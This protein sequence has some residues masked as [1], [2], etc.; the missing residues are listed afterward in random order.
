MSIERADFDAISEDD[1]QQLVDGQVPEGLRL[2]YKQAA[3]GTSDADKRELQKD[4]SALANASGGHLIIGIAEGD[5][6]A[7]ELIGLDAAG[8]D[9][10]LLRMENL[11]RS[12]IEP[13]IAGLRM[14]QIPLANG[15]QVIVLRIPR[16]WNSPHRVIA[17]G[18]NRFYLR[19]SAGVHE[20][21]MEELRAMFNRSESA[22][23][24]AM[25]FRDKRLALIKSGETWKPV[26]GKGQLVMH[27][28]PT[29]SFSGLIH[30]DLEQVRAAES[31]LRPINPESLGYTPR[32]NYEGF[33]ICDN[34]SAPKAYTQV[35]RDG[36]IEAVV[37]G[38]VYE[39]S[40]HTNVYATHVES[41]IFEGGINCIN[42]LRRLDVPPSLIVMI[43][44][45][46][47]DGAVYSVATGN[48]SYASYRSYA[49][50][51]SR[52]VVL[53]PP[54]VLEDYGEQ[55]TYHQ[56]LRPA[57]D[58]LWNA[59]GF[60]KAAWFNDDGMWVRPAR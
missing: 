6:V 49:Q 32:F 10:E 34:V 2:E 12:G 26:T 15:R 20:P 3:Y 39:D 44:L 31:N 51:I 16:S 4:V 42:A 55:I 19:H 52:E 40:G 36:C 50:P 58:T 8:V 29:A 37:S 23:D 24:R 30:L 22:L 57:I 35:F 59:T 27:I 21:S 56:A 13:R 7:S 25:A 43:S 38:V 47:T 17:Q 14:R 45:V 46:N 53:L 28:V 60:A 18:S 11:V 41:C 9:S 5:G 54:C 33:I 48:S 1:L